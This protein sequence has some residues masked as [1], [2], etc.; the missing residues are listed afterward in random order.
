MDLN[1]TILCE[2]F[3]FALFYQIVQKKIWPGFTALLNEREAHIAAG[4]ES[5]ALGH[6]TLQNATKQANLIVREAQ[7]KA[8]LILD[9]AEQQMIVLKEQAEREIKN[10]RLEAQKQ[11]IV[12]YENI[13][14]KF[15]IEA[16]TH[17]V[18]VAAQLCASVLKVD[19]NKE[20][21]HAL[22]KLAL[23]Q[24]DHA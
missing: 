9:E 6:Q 20:N 23:D 3:I 10:L 4:L 22:I 16:K 19:N 14:K 18:E 17:Y 2:F 5:A 8:Q 21:S 11:A 7:Q 12:D 24:L 13:K 1:A 15:L